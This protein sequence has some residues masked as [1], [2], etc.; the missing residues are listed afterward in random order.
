MAQG[1]SPQKRRLET[2]AS[3]ANIGQFLL[4]LLAFFGITASVVF[5]GGPWH[6]RPNGPSVPLP[7]PAVQPANNPQ[8]STPQVPFP[9]AAP[10]VQTRGATGAITPS[11]WVPAPSDPLNERAQVF[12]YAGARAELVDTKLG[13][14]TGTWERSGDEIKL[15][16]GRICAIGVVNE[17]SLP[18]LERMSLTAFPLSCRQGQQ[19]RCF[20][21]NATLIHD[22]LVNRQLQRG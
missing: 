9:L 14:L 10:Q 22:W 17:S 20:D 13:H 16:L 1:P 8:T 12:V 5:F 21:A 19:C 11:T 2:W 3:L 15:S 18:G 4:A 6:G 7:Q